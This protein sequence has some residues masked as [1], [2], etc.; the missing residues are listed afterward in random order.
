[1]SWEEII[2]SIILQVV[3]LLATV[4][5]AGTAIWGICAWRREYTGKRRIDLAEEILALV[6]E[7]RDVLASVRSPL[8]QENKGQTCPGA[9]DATDK[10]KAMLCA[11]YIPIERCSSRQEIFARIRSLRYR[12]MAQH[13]KD[14]GQPF[15]ELDLVRRSLSL[16]F[17]S[18]KIRLRDLQRKKSTTDSKEYDKKLEEL[19]E[20]WNRT[21]DKDEFNE[22]GEDLILRE[23]DAVIDKF[24]TLC[25]QAIGLQE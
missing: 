3:S 5:A 23:C 8:G 2:T 22:E 9:P 15:E 4:I 6:Y 18:M 16:P 25:R 14:A 24:E 20:D 19:W 21:K 17:Y 10:E 13:G 7:A 12:F 1:M 11:A